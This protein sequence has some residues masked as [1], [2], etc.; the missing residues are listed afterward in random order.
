MIPFI[1]ALSVFMIAF[2]LPRILYGMA[3]GIGFPGG[4][5]I[6]VSIG[7]AGVTTILY[8]YPATVFAGG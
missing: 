7:T 4:N 5:V 2:P 3:R 1:F 6:C 8:F